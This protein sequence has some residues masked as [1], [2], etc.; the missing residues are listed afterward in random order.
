LV[1]LG[2]S[3]GNL[4]KAKIGWGSCFGSVAHVHCGF[5]GIKN[6]TINEPQFG[7]SENPFMPGV[8]VSQCALATR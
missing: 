7:R 3:V 5:I 1:A 8:L 4:A 6:L 2:V